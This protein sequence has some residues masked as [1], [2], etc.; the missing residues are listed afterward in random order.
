MGLFLMMAIG[1]G[2]VA[3]LWTAGA[4]MSAVAL[5]IWLVFSVVW[6]LQTAYGVNRARIGVLE[7]RLDALNEEIAAADR[8]AAPRPRTP[9][10]DYPQPT[11]IIFQ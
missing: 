5:G 3:L 1:V 7:R 10:P 9:V 11:P 6:S 8:R 4:V 2:R